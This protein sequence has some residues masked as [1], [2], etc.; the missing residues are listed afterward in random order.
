M[1]RRLFTN[2]HSA[3]CALLYKM[4][5]NQISITVLSAHVCAFIP[6]PATRVVSSSHLCPAGLPFSL[7]VWFT[8]LII[9]ANLP[10]NAITGR[11]N[12]C[13]HWPSAPGREASNVLRR[14]R[15]S[16][17]A[18]CH[19]AAGARRL[20]HQPKLH[21]R[22]RASMARRQQPGHHGRRLR[23]AQGRPVGRWHQI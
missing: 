3:W 7:T 10:Q 23:P 18:A 8:V 19:S 2:L 11:A 9:G 14:C 13:R 17:N 20:V 15:R 6:A 4:A 5:H 1:R 12:P 16:S 21:I 22:P